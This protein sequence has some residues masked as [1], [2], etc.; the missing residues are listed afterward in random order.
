[1]GGGGGGGGSCTSN[2]VYTEESY[3]CKSS[4]LNVQKY[5]YMNTVMHTPVLLKEEQIA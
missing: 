2:I 1:M 5:M 4:H 3:T